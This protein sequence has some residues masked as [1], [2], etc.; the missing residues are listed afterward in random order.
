MNFTNVTFETNTSLI[1]ALNISSVSAAP[2]NESATISWNTNLNANST[3]EYGL[4]EDL[5]SNI[6]SASFV[7][8][9]SLTITGLTSN[10]LYYYNVTS[11]TSSGHCLTAGPYTFTTS[12]NVYVPPTAPRGRGHSVNVPPYISRNVTPAN[13]TEVIP[14]TPKAGIVNV[15]KPEL[16]KPKVEIPTPVPQLPVTIEKPIAIKFNFW[17]WI[18]LAI[19]ILLFFAILLLAKREEKKKPNLEKYVKKARK[20]GF[21]DTEIRTKLIESGWPENIVDEVLKK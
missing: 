19:V 11:C 1:P 10:T 21:S 7:L 5:G 18:V 14:I 20:E 15:T 13:V 3:V 9:R 8:A 17:P 6:S 4:S 12:Q 2:T 16:E